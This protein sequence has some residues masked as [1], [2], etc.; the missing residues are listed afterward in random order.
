MFQSTRLNEE[1]LRQL[2]FF[3]LEKQSLQ[4]DL[5]PLYIYE[6]GGCN[7]VEVSLFSQG[8]INRTREGGFRLC[9]KKALDWISEKN[10]F[11]EE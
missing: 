8:A 6:K 2:R 10:F 11:A 5:I 9:Q 7:Q 1:W 3:S 4:G